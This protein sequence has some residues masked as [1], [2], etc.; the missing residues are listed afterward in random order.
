[1]GLI[2]LFILAVAL[3]MDAFTVAICK[4]LAM[5]KITFIKMAVIGIY[6]GFF[7]AAMPLLGYLVGKRFEC[8]IL[9][10]DHWIAFF[11]LLAIGANMIK[12]ALG[13]HEEEAD[14]SIH[15][16]NMLLLSIA[17][18]IDA[19]AV[20]VA[21]AFLDVNIILA[22]LLIGITTFLISLIGVKIGHFIGIRFKKVAELLGG[23]TLIGLG[24]KILLEGL[25]VL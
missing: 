12:S 22:V 17:T 23:V 24:T 11:L 6:F 20:G 13:E 7:Q 9:I 25:G 5:K 10:F 18:S 2:S 3:S 21:F 1:M 14:G 15:V 16:K 19:M 8:Y 4:G